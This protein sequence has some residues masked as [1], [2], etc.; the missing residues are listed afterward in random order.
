[1]YFSPYISVLTASVYL[2][3]FSHRHMSPF[4]KML[5]SIDLFTH[6]TLDTE[7]NS[8]CPVCLLQSQRLNISKTVGLLHLKAWLCYSH[9]LCGR[10][11]WSMFLFMMCAPLCKSFWMVTLMCNPPG[12]GT[13]TAVAL[14]SSQSCMFF[15]GCSPTLPLGFLTTLRR[16]E[17][18]NKK[19]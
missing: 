6:S 3:M 8:K 18:T 5:G 10:S 14:C 9:A 11:A 17:F 7:F 19:L 4:Y 1:M 16:T 2:G 13:W 15:T 12:E